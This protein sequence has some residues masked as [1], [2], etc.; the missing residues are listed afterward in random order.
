MFQLENIDK[1]VVATLAENDH[2]FGAVVLFNTLIANGFSG[3][4]VIGTRKKCNIPIPLFREIENY[5]LNC[6]QSR[7]PKLVILEV[8][9]HFHFA[10]Y[11]PYFLNQL[12]DTLPNC[13]LVT[14]LDPDICFAAPWQ[15]IEECVLVGPV[16]AGDVN[17]C[18]PQ[19]HPTRSV[20]RGLLHDAGYDCNNILNIYFNSGMLALTRKDRGILDYWIV[21]LKKYGSLTNR[22]DV[23]GEIGSWMKGGRWDPTL[24][25]DQDTLNMAL[26]AWPGELCTFGPDFMGFMAGSLGAA[27][28]VGFGKPW[29]RRYCF[30]AL[31]GNAPRPVDKLFWLNA[32]SPLSPYSKMRVRWNKFLLRVLSL[33]SRFYSK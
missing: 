2:L 33:L 27:H 17:W 8:D 20:W 16:V 18:M 24:A 21:L 30:E 23:K 32:S 3:T 13:Q 31:K 7:V 11:K 26:M 9:T 5:Q 15:W 10:N 12:L 6:K 22:L 14:Y 1:T 19:C 28:A 29:K 25:P 4:Y